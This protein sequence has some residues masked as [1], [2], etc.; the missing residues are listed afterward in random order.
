[1]M[2]A[3]RNRCADQLRAM[4][5]WADFARL[6][7]M[8][9]EFAESAA[10]EL[11]EAYSKDQFPN[12]LRAASLSPV[13]MK[14]LKKECGDSFLNKLVLLTTEQEPIVKRMEEACS[15][16]TVTQDA[17]SRRTAVAEPKA[18]KPKNDKKDKSNTPESATA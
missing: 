9:A 6:A 1:M 15:K 12:K 11:D 13:L 7:Q 4:K 8:F 3:R 10:K 2:L 5:T 17:L 18:K 16:F 14:N